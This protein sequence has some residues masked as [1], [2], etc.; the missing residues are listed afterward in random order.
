MKTNVKKQDV[1]FSHTWFYN[2]NLNL[3]TAMFGLEIVSLAKVTVLIQLCL[4]S[5]IYFQF[6]KMYYP[7]A[8]IEAIKYRFFF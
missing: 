7:D 5:K 8:G 3:P 1:W 6:L 4:S 2:E